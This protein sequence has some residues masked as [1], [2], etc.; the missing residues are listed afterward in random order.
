[1]SRCSLSPLGGARSS[2]S[3][4]GGSLRDVCRV[5]QALH[6]GDHRSSVW[7]GVSS[8]VRLLVLQPLHR[9]SWSRSFRDGKGVSE[10]CVSSSP[11]L[12]SPSPSC[13]SS[14]SVSLSSYGFSSVWSSDPKCFSI[15][16]RASG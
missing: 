5:P 8:P 6:S 3:V 2:V 7:L 14:L 10:S 1:A 4:R 12:S 16:Y 15:G 9:N 11:S 13:D